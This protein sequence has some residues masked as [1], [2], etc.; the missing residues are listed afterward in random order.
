M[1]D[2]RSP[3]HGHYLL[4]S[5]IVNFSTQTTNYTQYRDLCCNRNTAET[6]V[7]LAIVAVTSVF[8]DDAWRRLPQV[9]LS[10]PADKIDAI[11]EVVGM[12]HNASLL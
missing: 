3:R 6:A 11:K 8:P 7:I 12:L 10:I 5:V 9:W 4:A 2:V 1:Q